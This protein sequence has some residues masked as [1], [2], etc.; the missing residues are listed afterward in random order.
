MIV[1]VKKAGLSP[2]FSRR[3]RVAVLLLLVV[4]SLLMTPLEAISTASLT[5]DAPLNPGPTGGD[6]MC[7]KNGGTREGLGW[8]VVG[9]MWEASN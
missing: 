7:T 9:C 5:H 4:V 2:F 1:L 3:S 6:G 8:V